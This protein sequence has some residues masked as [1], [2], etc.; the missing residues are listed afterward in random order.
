MEVL[1]RKPP[2]FTSEP[3]SMYQRKVGETVEMH[4]DA[5]ETEGTQKPTIQWQR[6]SVCFHFYVQNYI[7]IYQDINFNVLNFLSLPKGSLNQPVKIYLLRSRD[8]ELHL[9]IITVL[10]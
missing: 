7:H 6:V 4:C 1:V 3:D 9:D 10:W 2:V 5:Q 8:V